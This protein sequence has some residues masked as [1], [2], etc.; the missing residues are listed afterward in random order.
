ME[1]GDPVVSA[2]L[3]AEFKVSEDAIRRDLRALAADGVCQRVYGGALPL[4][5][6]SAGIMDRTH[7]G[8][9]EKSE[10]AKGALPL[11]RS[12]QTLFLDSSSTNLALAEILPLGRQLRVIT[13]SVP[14]AGVLLARPD[15][16]TC[17]IGGRLNLEIG[18]CIDAG[19]VAELQ[20]YSIDLCMLGA[21]AFAVGQGLAGFDPED[22]QFKR[23][24]VRTACRSAVMLTAEKIET[25]APYRICRTEDVAAY[26]LPASMADMGRQ[27][28]DTGRQVLFPTPS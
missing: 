16:E 17:L 14:I 1:A 7:E 26:V 25:T 23:A 24:L 12:N 2:S 5:P 20:L 4:S 28:T 8:M 19:A 18:G 27:L 6:A 10:L 3:A 9:G 22:V 11:I 13:N 15:V 21:C